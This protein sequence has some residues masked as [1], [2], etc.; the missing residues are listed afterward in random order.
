MAHGHLED[1]QVSVL[2]TIFMLH[3][4]QPLKCL[5]KVVCCRVFIPALQQLNQISCMH[6]PKHC[7]QEKTLNCTH[8]WTCSKSQQAEHTACE[9]WTG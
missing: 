3:F 6:T 7:D 4:Q 5:A 2:R 8:A 1:L 9:C